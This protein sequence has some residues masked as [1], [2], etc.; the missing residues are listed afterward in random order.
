M[1]TSS[2][3]SP[4]ELYSE[5]RNEWAALGRTIVAIG[6]ALEVTLCPS[7]NGVVPAGKRHAPFNGNQMGMCVVEDA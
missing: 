1:T 5:L 6:K 4:E 2:S 3:Y 7:C